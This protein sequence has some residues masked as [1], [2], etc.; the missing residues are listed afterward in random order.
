MNDPL[1]V[2]GCTVGVRAAEE[3]IAKELRELERQLHELTFKDKML[4]GTPMTESEHG[5]MKD[6]I[7]IAI[8]EI[9]RIAKQLEGE[10]VTQ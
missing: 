3:R 2:A 5:I 7:S 1:F 6:T 9:E 8:V 10:A 4:D